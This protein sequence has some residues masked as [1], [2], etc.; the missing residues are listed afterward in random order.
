MS[1]IYSSEV[2]SFGDSSLTIQ[3]ENGIYA[4]RTSKIPKVDSDSSSSFHSSMDFD[5]TSLKDNKTPIDS[6]KLNGSHFYTTPLAKEI[7]RKFEP[8]N[9]LKLIKPLEQEIKSPMI[10]NIPK[11]IERLQNKGKPRFSNVEEQE[12]KAK[13][14]IV[15]GGRLKNPF[16]KSS[17]D[18]SKSSDD[19]IP[20]SKAK[21]NNFIR[22]NATEKRINKRKSDHLN[23]P[24]AVQKDEINRLNGINPMDSMFNPNSSKMLP[25][26]F[27]PIDRNREEN[28]PD[29][30]YSRKRQIMIRNILFQG[31]EY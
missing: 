4:K 27:S 30:G 6:T 14:L 7:S 23:I 5:N 8:G 17:V 22:I 16:E 26:L 29:R 13:I 3:N 31:S 25:R 18:E 1:S 2:K 21:V 24:Y 19:Y 15:E 10:S 9:Y 11:Y 12:R 20:N 28:K